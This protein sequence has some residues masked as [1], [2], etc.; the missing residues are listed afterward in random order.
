MHKR[1]ADKLTYKVFMLCANLLVGAPVT[2]FTTSAE[3]K[4]VLYFYRCMDVIKNLN[5]PSESLRH[6]LFSCKC[7]IN[8]L[9][10][11][12]RNKPSPTFSIY[13][14]R[15]QVT[16]IIFHNCQKYKSSLLELEEGV[17]YK[18]NTTFAHEY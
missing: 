1:D 9:E 3:S 5:T 7:I 2:V 13:L 15:I 12:V 18:K 6:T 10:I 8:R 14:S 16:L 11:R 17:Q 4:S